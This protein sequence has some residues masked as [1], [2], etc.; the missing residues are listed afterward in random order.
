M[1][2]HDDVV[3]FIQAAQRQQHVGG[4]G[5]AFL[6]AQRLAGHR[7]FK[8]GRRLVHIGGHVGD[9]VQPVVRGTAP[10]L[11][12]ELQALVQRFDDAVGAGELAADDF[13]QLMNILGKAGLADV[14]RLVGAEGRRDRDLDRGV[15]FDLL[16]PFQAVDGVVGGAH[17]GDVALLDQ[18]AHRQL[19]VVLQFFIAQVPDLLRGL[20]VE[21]AL[22]AEVFLQLQVAPGVHRVADAHLQR[23]G[24]F[25]E[26][27]AVGFVAGDVF[28]RHAVGAHHAPLVVV[29]KIVVAAV[30]QHL[31]AAQPY[32]GDVLK[33]AVLI[34]LLRGDVAVVVDD[35][36]LGRVI[37]VQMLR[38]G[39]VQQKVFV[40][41][42]FHVQA[43]LNYK[44]SVAGTGI[45]GCVPA[46]RTAHTLRCARV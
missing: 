12:K 41:K 16:V 45:P 14:Q 26:A 7:L 15:V 1:Q 25:L 30:G 8:G 32:L 19:G 44:R 21:H 23:L 39:G 22:I 10:H 20:A 36:Q 3:L 40:H 18:A 43:L 29:A 31:V 46:G 34:D 42:C 13:F 4:V 38:G 17:H 5:V 33:A 11:H 37:V 35:G 28:L 6:L 9:V 2:L 27:L 24:K